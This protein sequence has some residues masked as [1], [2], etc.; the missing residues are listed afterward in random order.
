M[1]SIL[2]GSYCQWCLIESR[3]RL[4]RFPV[5][6]VR[7]GLVLCT[8]HRKRYLGKRDTVKSATA[9]APSERASAPVTQHVLYRWG[10]LVET[11]D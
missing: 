10:E 7:G 6:E 3:G 2:P 1:C 5:E 11:R 8:Y 4:T 9:C